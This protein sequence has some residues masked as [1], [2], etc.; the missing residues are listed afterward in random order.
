MNLSYLNM[1][2]K[3]SEILINA[4]YT[5]CIF[6]TVPK[7]L[8]TVNVLQTSIILLTLNPDIVYKSH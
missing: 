6:I 2:D 7:Y 5:C 3:I 8:G 4:I 1:S